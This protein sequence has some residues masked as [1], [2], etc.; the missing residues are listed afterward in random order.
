MGFRAQ[1]PQPPTAYPDRWR[2]V[3]FDHTLDLAGGQEWHS[4]AVYLYQGPQYELSRVGTV[5]SYARVVSEAEYASLRPP[6][7][8]FPFVFGSDRFSNN[9]PFTVNIPGSFR[10]VLRVGVFNPPGRI[11][12]ALTRI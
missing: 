3:L 6:S 4:P 10:V 5:K 2:N 1:M 12:I 7:G 9:Y 11:R 8:P